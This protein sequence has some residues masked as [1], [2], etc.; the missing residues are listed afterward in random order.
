MIYKKKRFIVDLSVVFPN[1]CYQGEC[2]RGD[3]CP[4]RHE[5]P[6]DPDD[7]LADQNIKDR[8][9]GNNDPVAHK[10]MQRAQAMPRIEPPADKS[11][12]TLYIGNIPRGKYTNHIL[13]CNKMT[14]TIYT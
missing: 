1:N 8:Y 5:K 2:K 7:P 3:E 14:H 13:R 4:Y 9:Y 11:I 6:T 12:T 10:L